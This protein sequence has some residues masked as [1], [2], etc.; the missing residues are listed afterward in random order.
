[1]W[2]M[3]TI[4]KRCGIAD[5]QIKQGFTRC[6]SQRILCKKCGCKYTPVTKLWDEKTKELAIRAYMHGNSARGTGR[7]FGCDGNTVTA[8]VKNFQTKSRTPQFQPKS[9]K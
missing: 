1:M 4:C 8:W 5:N 3:G 7:I 2:S 9:P 6:G